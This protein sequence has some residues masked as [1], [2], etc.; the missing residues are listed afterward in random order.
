MNPCFGNEQSIKRPKLTHDSVMSL[1]S[2]KAN[3]ETSAHSLHFSGIPLNKLGDISTHLSCGEIQE[4]QKEC[5]QC[6]L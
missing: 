2:D 5:G 6:C 4:L 3:S 1:S